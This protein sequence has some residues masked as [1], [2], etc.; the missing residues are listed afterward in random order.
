MNQT[1]CTSLEGILLGAV[2]IN[3]PEERQVYLERAC[4]GNEDLRAKLEQL[5]ANYFRAGSFLEH[6]VAVL[7]TTTLPVQVEAPGT[8]IGPYKLLEQV[9]EG[10]MGVVYVAEQHHPVRRTVALKLIKPGMDS[11]QVIA[12]FEAERQALALMD[13]PNIAKVLDAGTTDAGRPY[14]VMELVRGIPITEYCDQA[15]LTV[16]QRLEVFVQVCRAVQHAHTK[17]VIHRDLK[18]SNVLVTSHDGIPVPLVIDFGV[19]KALGNELTEKTLHTGFAQMIGTP[20]YMSPEQA[21][22]NKFGV[23]T[24]SDI[25]SLGV[26]LY[27]LLTGVTPFDGL[28]L[29]TVNHDEFRRILREEEPPRPSNQ[30]STLGASL[31]T[32]SERRGVD[33]RKL[34]QTLHGEL[35]WIVMKCLDKD[36]TR[37]YETA[38]NFAADVQRYLNDEAVEASP[39]SKLYRLRKFAR[40]H[41]AGLVMTAL[42]FLAV[43]LGGSSWLWWIGKQTGAESEARIALHEARELLEA[44]H[45]HEALSAARRAEG[46]LAGVGGDASLCQQARVLVKDLEMARRLQEAQLCKMTI[47]D[48]HFDDEAVA[49]AYATAFRDYGLDVERLDM[50]TAVE[51]VRTRSIHHRLVAALDDWANTLWWHKLEGLGPLL[52]LTRAADPDPWR[53][54]LRDYQEGKDPKAVE[55]LAATNGAEQLPVPTLVILGKLA[56]M[57]ASAERVAVLLTRVQQRHPD[58]FWIIQSLMQLLDTS[59]SGRME[60]MIRFASISVAL[61]PH[62]PG[63]HLNLGYALH[64]KGQLDEAFAE[65]RE[66][67]R[68]KKDYPLAHNNLGVVLEDKGQLDE[69][70]AEFREAIRLQN[71]L[72]L[73]HNNLGFVLQKKGQLDEAIAEHRESVRLQKDFPGAHYNLGIA[74]R[75]KGQL[76][77]AIEEYREAIRLKKD[78]PEAHSNLGVALENKGQL[79]EAIAEYREA[80]RLKKDLP[81]GHCNLGIALAKKGQLDEAIPEYREAIRLKKDFPEAHCN[82]GIALKKKGQLDEAIAEFRETIRLKK[83]F[84]EGHENLGAALEKKGQLDEAIAEYREAIRLKNDYPEIHYNLGNALMEA[85]RLA[86]AVVEYRQAIRLNEGL[87]E[88]HCN[89]GHVLLRSGQ[90]HKAVEEFRRGHELGS[91]KPSWP[92]PSAQWIKGGERFIELEAKLPAI[93][94]GQEQ[95][96][97]AKERIEYAYIFQTK[98]MCAAAARYYRE[99]FAANPALFATPGGSH[100]FNAA[101]AA[102]LASIGAGQDAAQLTNVERANLRQQALDWLRAE[103]SNQSKLYEKGSAK[104]RAILAK[105]LR[106]WLQDTDLAAVRDESSLARLPIDEKQAWSK[107]WAEVRET[108]RKANQ[109]PATEKKPQ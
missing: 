9:G 97:T 18:P 99:A 60:D 25:Y 71:D 22:F 28:R 104:G 44:E 88:V 78:Y 103:L 48:G 33:P 92:Y 86:E 40:R 1:P 38:S 2:E 106:H 57:T 109:Q 81:E 91:K 23:D 7:E 12:R 17:G 39:P 90:F 77:E 73:V 83:D 8:Q 49:T 16:R 20:L 84:F 24:R 51:Q 56:L 105:T 35:D 61:R 46:V 53:N 45:W 94:S 54:R 63:A 43:V 87:A 95:P 10:G 74:L 13:H 66:A 32:V 89:L 76:D 102:A 50:R 11:K 19:A 3:S 58:D 4:A 65:F 5:M 36:R 79:D 34:T 41:K 67:I 107:F 55:E 68:L 82:L 100:H 26:L 64:R 15:R 29:R 47:K 101:C 108:L 93:L 27:E 6:P 21:E 80:I 96:A 75:N 69:A 59:Q 62:S 98:S 14:F 72:P 31:S 37:R 85:S 52:A 42:L 70:I 30:L